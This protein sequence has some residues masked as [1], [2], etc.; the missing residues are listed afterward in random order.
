M[1]TYRFYSEITII[2]SFVSTYELMLSKYAINAISLLL[3]MDAASTHN[4]LCIMTMGDMMMVMDDIV[5][6]ELELFI[7]QHLDVIS[8]LLIYSRT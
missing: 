7:I 8:N 6:A 3:M 5:R 1:E 4:V 2:H